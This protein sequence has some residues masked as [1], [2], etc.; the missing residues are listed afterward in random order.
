[1]PNNER[2]YVAPHTPLILI[3]TML[4]TQPA[5]ILP[6]EPFGVQLLR[7]EVERQELLGGSGNGEGRAGNGGP[8]KGSSGGSGGTTAPFT[9]A[10]VKLCVREGAALP[11]G[12]RCVEEVAILG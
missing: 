2:A 5:V 1:G 6:E 8:G 3:L 4:A 7:R 9:P 11:G 12:D 10:A